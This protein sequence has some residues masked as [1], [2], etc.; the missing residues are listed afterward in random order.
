MNLSSEYSLWFIPLCI[1]LAF[2]GTWFLYRNNPLKLE[3]KWLQLLLAGLRFLA[4]FLVIMLLLGLLLKTF[5]RKV[6]KPIVVLALDNSESVTAN[7]FAS[8]Y[9]NEYPAKT[10]KLITALRENYDLKVYSFGKRI[11]ESFK[12]GFNEKQTDIS[13]VLNEVENR[14][15]NMNLGAVVLAT[16][17]IYNEGNN[18][19]YESKKLN[20]PV[21]TIALGDS[22]Q[23]QDVLIKN[24]RHN[25]LVFA[26]NQFEVQVDLASYGYK[27]AT[28]RLSVEQNGQN[29][30]TQSLTVTESNY[31]KTLSFMLPASSEGTQHYKVHVSELANELS[32]TNN[33]FDFFVEVIKSKQKI[34]LVYQSPHPDV[35]AFL[36][37]VSSNPNYECKAF[38]LS[39]FEMNEAARYDLIIAHQLP[40]WKAEGFN[41]LKQLDESGKSVLNIIGAQTNLNLLGNLGHLQIEGNRGAYNEATAAY[42]S[43]NTSLALA[44][45]NSQALTK[46]PPLM[47][48]Y[49]RYRYAADAV[50]VLKQN[51][52]YVQTNEPLLLITKG[53]K[54]KVAYLCGE[55]FWKWR[56]N[57]FGQHAN[58]NTTQDFVSKLVQSLAARE[59]KSLFR[60]KPEKRRFAENE[61]V[62]FNAELYNE[63]YELQNQHDIEL[64]ILNNVSKSFRFSFS[65]TGKAYRLD[66]GLL[67]VGNYR[68]R[69]TVNRNGKTEQRSGT[70]VVVALQQELLQTKAEHQLLNSISAESGGQMVFPGD[71]ERIATLIAEDQSVR[72]VVY[73]QAKVDDLMNVKTLFFIILGLLGAEWFIRKWYGII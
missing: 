37:S 73:R 13:A 54:A 30:Y 50:V 69:A 26:G 23:Q 22:M 6:E 68:Y 46:M 36:H 60:L 24:V 51:I 63:A 41:L 43:T 52:G 14:Y 18:P 61:P 15:S 53:A 48:P 29:L 38:Q 8:F 11:E 45:E 10:E 59:D 49:G 71:M 58:H 70:F 25:E 5:S 34:A 35:G 9:K 33:H 28:L 47:V 64:E 67:P 62:I 21:Y 56:L 3:K 12:T 42:N 72:P 4:L 31:F 66:A 16:D 65:K 1:A 32:R 2:A 39:D 19:Y 40:G 20:V 44:S 7:R 55:G 27:N 57:D 17:G